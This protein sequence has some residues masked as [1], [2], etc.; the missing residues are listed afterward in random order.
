MKNLQLTLDFFENNIDILLIKELF[1][2]IKNTQ[3]YTH[4]NDQELYK[5]ESTLDHIL[6]G[7]NTI[8][9]KNFKKYQK[10]IPILQ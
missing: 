7:L 1:K 5:I 8:L 6:K 10:L 4:I 3:I 2:S 9:N